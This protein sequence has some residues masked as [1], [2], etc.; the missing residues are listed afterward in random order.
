MITR[1][2][3]TR[4][5]VIALGAIAATA[6]IPIQVADAATPPAKLVIDAPGVTVLK[7]GASAFTA[8]KNNQALNPGDTVQTDTTGRA[9]LSFKDGSLTRLDANSIFTL[10]KLVTTTGKRQIA[11]SMRVGQ[12]WNRVEKLSQSEAFKQSANGATAGVLGTAFATTCLAA[13]PA[14]VKTRSAL[15]KVANPESCRFTVIDG[16]VEVQAR[17]GTVTLDAGQGVAIDQNGRAADP[18]TFAPDELYSRPWIQQN[19][20]ADAAAGLTFSSVAPTSG[21]I[22]GPW[23][24]EL[25]VTNATNVVQPAVGDVL[26]RMYTIT[27][28]CSDPVTCTLTLTFT[29]RASSRT[30]PLTYA[31]GEYTATEPN[32]ATSDCFDLSTGAVIA[33]SAAQSRLDLSFKPTAAALVAG[34]PTATAFSGQSVEQVLPLP[35]FEGTCQPGTINYTSKGSR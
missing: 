29:T 23:N 27:G 5:L 7:K 12:A 16:E 3:F 2:L 15:A 22:L 32:L 18:Q 26:N 6:A 28:T 31:N 35:G 17:G 11:G 21:S 33:R 34:I 25:L 9:E 14:P 19:L 30:V 13:A 4:A 8:A 20:K 10:D 1:P 24:V